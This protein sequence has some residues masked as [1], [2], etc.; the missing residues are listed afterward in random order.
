MNRSTK[1]IGVDFAS[2]RRGFHKRVQN[3]SVGKDMGNKPTKG[4]LEESELNLIKWG[5]DW[6]LRTSHLGEKKTNI[7]LSP[8]EE[9]KINIHNVALGDMSP[10]QQHIHT[11]S[12]ESTSTK[13]EVTPIV[14]IHGYAQ[15]ASQFYAAAPVLSKQYP[16]PVHAIDHIG[17]GLS[18]R[19]AWIGGFGND[20]DLKK[21]EAIFV[22]ALEQWREAM[23]IER[24][25]LAA[26]SM[27]AY[28]SVRYCEKFPWRVEKLILLSPA[29]VPEKP[30]EDPANP[31]KLPWYFRL[32]RYLW[33]K[34]YG[35]FDLARTV[36]RR[37]SDSYTFRRYP[38]HTWI[39][40]PLLADQLYYN[41]IHGEV[42]VGG[43]CHATLLTP[44]AFAREPLC[45]T[46]LSV[47]DTIGHVTF[48]YGEKDWMT[49]SAAE[50]LV[51]IKRA[52]IAEGNGNK[53]GRYEVYK[54]GNCGHSFLVDNPLA[55]VDAIMMSLDV[56]KA[57]KMN[58]TLIGGHYVQIDVTARTPP[59][60]AKQAESKIA[61]A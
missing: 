13:S 23:G 59:A 52:Q 55:L 2:F 20:S 37:I 7:N 19:D 43:Y 61:N 3:T 53:H 14:L 32:G 58:T 40:K 44:G 30:Q 28:T 15:S 4:L 8:E 33:D 31:P 12:Y 1:K 29:G 34:G 36:G 9:C 35:P 18:T 47:M 24:M 54:L 50:E 22:D 39:P 38:D 60:G 6:S 48:V 45:R 21:T 16:G 11:L 17:C 46:L 26:H 51:R 42:S 25:I 57:Y 49:V 41:W 5:R 27:G 10:N 56:S